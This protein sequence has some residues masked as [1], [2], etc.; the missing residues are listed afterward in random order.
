M[1]VMQRLFK[2]GKPRALQGLAALIAELRRRLIACSAA[3]RLIS[4]TPAT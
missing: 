4:N 3:H 1:I 2:I